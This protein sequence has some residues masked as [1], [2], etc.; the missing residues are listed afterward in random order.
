MRKNGINRE[1]R[2]IEG[3]ICAPEGFAANAVACGIRKEGGLDLAMIYTPK[4][5]SVGCVYASGKN[6]GAPVKVSKKNMRNGYARAIVVNGGVANALG[7]DGE[8]L[9]FATCDAFFPFGLERT[10]I[11]L[12]STGYMGEPFSLTA[13]KEGARPLWKGLT[14]DFE[15]SAKVVEAIQGED[16]SA[17]Q[18]SF[19][20]DLGDYPCKMGVI[21]KGGA[22]TAPNMATFLAFLTTDVNISTPMLQKAL[23]AETKETLNMLNVDGA[24]SPN[25]TVCILANGKAGNYRIDVE[26]S[27]YKKFT[28]ALRAVLTE[29]CKEAAKTGAKQ[30]LVCRVQGGISKEVARSVAKTVV[31]ADGVKSGVKKGRLSVESLLCAAL[32]VGYEVKTEGAEIRLRSAFGEVVLYE[33]KRTLPCA[34]ER[35]EKLLSAK[36]VA[37][38]IDFKE[39]NFGGTAYGRI[40]E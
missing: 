4:R 14:S 13:V 22:Q 31:G 34:A 38:E 37:I 36:E 15:Q 17:K 3:G 23:I 8:R 16:G 29:V 5:C 18:L 7:G 1:L 28:Y 33:Q 9:G 20:F 40:C 6:V 19:A 39:G 12:A 21:F 11:V 25:D 30:I 27:E 10:E 35:M 26:D 32:S 2:P 24:P